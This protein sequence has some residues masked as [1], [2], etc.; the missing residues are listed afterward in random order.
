M[1]R[2]VRLVTLA[3]AGED[4]DAHTISVSARHEAVLED[5]SRVLLLDDRGW[6]ESLRGPGADA[7]DD[8]WAVT[9]EHDIVETTRVVVGPDEPYGG[10]TQEDME[11]GHWNTLAENL[12]AHGVVVDASELRQLPH[13]V[14]LSDRLLARLGRGPGD[15]A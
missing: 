5:G 8:L 6:T 10:R 3:D 13:D 15:T 11:T 7:I 4:V 14:V 2:V 9:P 1:R 12:H